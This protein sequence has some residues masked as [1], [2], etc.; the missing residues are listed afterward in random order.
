VARLGYVLIPPSILNLV[1]CLG[2]GHTHQVQL[3]F[4]V[5]PYDGQESLGFEI[6]NETHLFLTKKCPNSAINKNDPLRECFPDDVDEDA[7]DLIQ[8]LLRIDPRKRYSARD[9]LKHQFLGDAEVLYDYD[10]EVPSEELERA[11][12]SRSGNDARLS[13][14]NPKDKYVKY[15]PPKYFEFEC[16]DA[17]IPVSVLKEFIEDEVRFGGQ[18]GPDSY[19]KSIDFSKYVLSNNEIE[20]EAR[21]L[22]EQHDLEMEMAVKKQPTKE[23]TRGGAEYKQSV[24]EADSKAA[25]DE[26]VHKP[27]REDKTVRRPRADGAEDKHG[28]D[29]NTAGGQ[30]SEKLQKWIDNLGTEQDILVKGA[31]SN[32]ETHTRS[33]RVNNGAEHKETTIYG[34]GVQSG[35]DDAVNIPENDRILSAL[36]KVALGDEQTGLVLTPS[37]R[38][39]QMQDQNL[40][41]VRKEPTALEAVVVDRAAR[42]R[43]RLAAQ[44]VRRE[45]ILQQAHMQARRVVAPPE[46]KLK[47]PLFRQQT[48][49]ERLIRQTTATTKPIKPDSMLNPSGT[50]SDDDFAAY[51]AKN[52]GLNA[53][54]TASG[55]NRT[56]GINH[57][58]TYQHKAV[59]EKGIRP[60][61]P[62]ARRPTELP[63][64]SSSLRA[65]RASLLT[66][67]VKSSA[68][69]SKLFMRADGRTAK[70]AG[71]TEVAESVSARNVGIGSTRPIMDSQRASNI[72]N[73]VNP[74]QQLVKPLSKPSQRRLSADTVIAHGSSLPQ[75]RNYSR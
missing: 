66:L 51:F 14:Y 29:S 67:P 22:Q 62:F 9:A 12:K 2:K 28:L 24:H 6:S 39:L 74:S 35:D 61:N 65:A 63:S 38:R 47:D 32:V 3:I 72:S 10:D 55:S 18:I 33:E 75:I 11:A 5:F 16:S 58:S 7:L 57:E 44:Q 17:K 53:A 15:P 49:T 43:A 36:S 41:G 23:Q 68:A 71:D 25:Y 73:S 19:Y 37:T 20:E 26:T 40:P 34:G 21:K 46:G 48:Y 27:V 64:S 8:H 69:A 1:S 54:F 70:D 45:S 56:A 50:K 60:A 13:P 4:S 42:A 59:S 30:L 52:E 31:A